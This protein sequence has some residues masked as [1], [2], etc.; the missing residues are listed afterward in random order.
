MELQLNKQRAESDINLFDIMRYLLANWKWFVLSLGI[1]LTV[2]YYNFIHAPRT[3]FSSLDIM[4]K[5][6]SGSSS[7]MVGLDKYSSAI[8]AVNVSNEMHMLRSKELLEKMVRETKAYM[9][10]TIRVQLYQ[11][12]MYDRQP[13]NIEFCDTIHDQYANFEMHIKNSEYCELSDF[14]EGSP[15][16]KVPFGKEVDTP[17]GRLI[18]TLNERFDNTWINLTT[19]VTRFTVASIVTY[20]HNAISIRQNDEMASILTLSLKDSS[21]KRAQA[22]LRGLIKAY[23]EDAREIKQ[24]VSVNTA[25]F[26]NERIAIITDELGEVESKLADFKINNKMSNPDGIAERYMDETFDYDSKMF[27]LEVEL[28]MANSLIDYFNNP[29]NSDKL[30]PTNILMTGSAGL[31]TQISKINSL[32]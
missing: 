11:E 25:N 1:C 26:I 17:A 5:D 9:L 32:Q 19:H 31:N 27:D 7:G 12:D 2:A 21:H 6:P 23:N 22:V 29:A 16:V 24:Q 18:I 15:T 13:V 8:N 20:Y 14:Y 10:Y 3:Y 28:R 30:I 4:I